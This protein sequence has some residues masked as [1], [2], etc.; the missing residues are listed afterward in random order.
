MINYRKDKAFL[1]HTPGCGKIWTG[2]LTVPKGP[3]LNQT[4]SR[5][6]LE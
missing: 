5:C 4:K 6:E 1:P 3:K 2:K